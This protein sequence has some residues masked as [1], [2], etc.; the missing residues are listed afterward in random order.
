MGF[1]TY[2]ET[3]SMGIQAAGLLQAE[4]FILGPAQ[5]T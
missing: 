2:I 4:I 1:P 5:Q 3:T